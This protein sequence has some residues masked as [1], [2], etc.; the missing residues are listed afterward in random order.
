MGGKGNS[1]MV[2][3]LC[4]PGSQVTKRIIGLNKIIL[5]NLLYPLP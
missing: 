5:Q 1:R 2:Y 4:Q 3:F